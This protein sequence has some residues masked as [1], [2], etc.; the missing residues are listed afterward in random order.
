MQRCKKTKQRKKEFL[1]LTPGYIRGTEQQTS[2]SACRSSGPLR[3]AWSLRETLSERRQSPAH[4]SPAGPRSSTSPLCWTCCSH[5]GTLPPASVD[6]QIKQLENTN[7]PWH[8]GTA[9]LMAVYFLTVSSRSSWCKNWAISSAVEPSM[10]W[11]CRYW[12][13]RFGF[14]LKLRR[15]KV[16][17]ISTEIFPAKWLLL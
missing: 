6:A 2:P 8:S 16:A 17:H 11:S 14:L 1:A 7:S 13:P 3:A 4:R 5:R 12:T 10:P 15:E 9:W